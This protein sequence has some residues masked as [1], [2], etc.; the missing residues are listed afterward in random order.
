MKTVVITGA[1]SGIGLAAAKALAYR[2]YRIIGVG[3]AQA[4]CD[5]ARQQLA[6]ETGN[7][8]ITYVCGDLSRQ[9][10]VNRI[11]DE[12]AAILNEHGEERLHALINN[13]GGVRSWYETTPEGYELQF[14]LNH[15]AGFLLTHRLMPHLQAADG[16]VIM[17]G[18]GSHRYMKMRWDDIM[19]QKRYSCL[20]AYKQS[21]LCNMLFAAELN[22]RYADSGICAYVVDPGLVRTDI[23][24]KQTGGI[25]SRFWAVRSRR[26]T[27]PDVPAET[28]AYLC[29]AQPAPEGVVLLSVQHAALQPACERSAGRTAFV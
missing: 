13:A 22:R 23:G 18:S 26:G 17:T 25:V 24:R 9:A 3:R 10:D 2:G 20:M 19:F 6:A 28:Y 5:A 4:R 1:T 12:I 15:L 21:K 14:A 8:D 11:A 7:A 29:D 16:R 27:A